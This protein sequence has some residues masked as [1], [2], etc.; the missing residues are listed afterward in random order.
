MG[1]GCRVPRPSLG[2]S[3]PNTLMHLPAWKPSESRCSGYLWKLHYGS[4][5]G[6]ITGQQCASSISLACLEVRE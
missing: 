4:L 5:V 2:V 3:S 1:K 6:E